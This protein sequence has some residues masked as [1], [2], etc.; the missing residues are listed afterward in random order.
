MP[1]D[2]SLVGQDIE[3]YRIVSRISAGGM[4]IV[5]K[6][7][8]KQLEVV[9]A[10]KVLKSTLAEDE[11]YMVRFQREAKNLAQLNH[12]N[13][14][15]VYA[16][17]P[18]P[19]HP[20]IVMEFVEGISLG[21]QIKRQGAIAYR[22]ALPLFKQILQGM[23]YAHRKGIIH[24]DIK[25]SNILLA[26]EGPV[27]IADFG[28]A[29]QV[30][31][32]DVTITAATMGTLHYMSPEQV[33]SMARVDH[34]SDIY[35]VGMTFYEAL[36]GRTPFQPDVAAYVVLKAISEGNL[37][38]PSQFNPTIPPK[39]DA[40]VKQSLT[41][42]PEARYQSADEMLE[43]LKAFE[44]EDL[45]SGGFR[46]PLNPPSRE[47]TKTK[48]PRLDPEKAQPKRKGAGA[49]LKYA[50]GGFVLITIAAIAW[51]LLGDSGSIPPPP[52][53]VP[54]LTAT[55]DPGIYEGRPAT[56]NVGT[57]N[58]ALLLQVLPYGEVSLEG[59]TYTFTPSDTEPV[60]VTVRAGTALLTFSHPRYGTHQIDVVVT[61]G[62]SKEVVCYFEGYVRVEAVDAEGMPVEAQLFVDNQRT[63]QDTPVNGFP[64]SPGVH[65][66]EVYRE[67]YRL[68]SGA[69]TV[70][71]SSP[72]QYEVTSQR[73]AETLRFTLTPI[74]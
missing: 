3:H 42:D 61:E 32:E 22:K 36:A 40:I 46:P 6:A 69:A 28:L 29:K 23:A 2:T 24:R 72:A 1:M 19:H 58:G 65:S 54:A 39:L 37:A 57:R 66:V 71:V 31:G 10:I 12:P 35:S 21:E 16:C 62:R 60:D 34:R 26:Q 14:I 15:T 43:A 27:K 52:R 4:G 41:K 59:R 73:P 18:D 11:E 49:W 17:Y 74:Q 5:Y 47:I 44:R 38:P 56:A 45:R 25:P 8:D 70:T 50:L 9:R 67:G 51:V 33:L 55:I 63:G 68:A 64:L 20:F 48:T 13:I 7:I 53:P 30:E